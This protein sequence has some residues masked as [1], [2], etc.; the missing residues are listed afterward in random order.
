MKKLIRYLMLVV[1]TIIFISCCGNTE[2]DETYNEFVQKDINKLKLPIVLIGKGKS[3]GLYY[4]VIK[5]STGSIRA[6]GN[7][8]SIANAIGE[9]RS[10]GDT[11]IK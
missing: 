5:D 4:I 10:V 2:S 7:L 3:M 11:I 9:S 8:S 1:I 6:Y